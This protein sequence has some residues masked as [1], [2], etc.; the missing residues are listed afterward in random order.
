MTT[1]EL[2][3]FSGRQLGQEQVVQ[4]LRDSGYVQENY[5]GIPA[6]L[7]KLEKYM[8]GSTSDEDLKKRIEAGSRG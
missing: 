5:A 4:L 1:R 2:V 8:P 7:W 3:D 6:T